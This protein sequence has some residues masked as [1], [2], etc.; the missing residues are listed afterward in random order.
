MKDSTYK[1]AFDGSS[2]FGMQHVPGPLRIRLCRLF[3]RL[4]AN[5]KLSGSK[6]VY[7]RGVAK[8]CKLTYLFPSNKL[9]VQTG[10]SHALV[11]QNHDGKLKILLQLGP[12]VANQLLLQCIYL[13][14]IRA[15]ARCPMRQ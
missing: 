14:Q 2:I 11:P 12:L 4:K 7:V 8:S 6:Y 13:H 15:G 1:D 5:N 10:L 9:P 3:L